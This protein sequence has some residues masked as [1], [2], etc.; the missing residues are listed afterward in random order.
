MLVILQRMTFQMNFLLK[1]QKGVVSN[2]WN[3]VKRGESCDSFLAN[4]RI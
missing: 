1:V 4:R 3:E 2:R